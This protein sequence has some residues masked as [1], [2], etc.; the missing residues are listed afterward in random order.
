MEMNNVIPHHLF[1]ERDAD[2]VLHLLKENPR[3]VVASA[4]E[5]YLFEQ[6]FHEVMFF[7]LA[8]RHYVASNVPAFLFEQKRVAEITEAV[9]NPLILVARENQPQ[10]LEKE[11]R[12][13]LFEYLQHH[14]LYEDS[15]PLLF[16]D[17][18]EDVLDFFIEHWVLGAEGERKLFDMPYCAKW[19]AK[20]LSY[21]NIVHSE[22]ELLLF[23][24]GMQFFRQ[25]Y[26][27]QS[28]FHCREA[29]KRL[30]EP[31]F[32]EDL[33]LYVECGRTFFSDHMPLFE[34]AASFSLYNQYMAGK[35]H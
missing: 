10:L 30:F 34:K 9:K 22:H 6:P 8:Q 32:A 2:S 29:E 23:G 5:P 26:I 11:F 21:H 16:A 13:A 28:D 15:Q 20:Y 12:P 18:N 3:A 1:E 25:K 35:K 7:Y 31:M 14:S 27:R 17:G 24:Y 4:D 19:L 33:A